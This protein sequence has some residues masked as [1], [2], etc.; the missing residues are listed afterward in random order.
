MHPVCRKRKPGATVQASS[1]LTA[2]LHVLA[3]NMLVFDFAKAQLLRSSP[4]PAR[5]RC[6]ARR[7][8][9][10]T[11]ICIA[12]VTFWRNEDGALQARGSHPNEIKLRSAR[13]RS[14][15][16]PACEI[17]KSCRLAHNWLE[18]RATNS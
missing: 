5:V 13:A 18:T 3:A 6:C 16:S 8:V 2:D 11:L 10:R 15:R 9:H 1:S 17:C 7:S 4:K 14:Q 12:L